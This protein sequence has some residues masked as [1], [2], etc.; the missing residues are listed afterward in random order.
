MRWLITSHHLLI[1]TFI[2]WLLNNYGI[3]STKQSF[4]WNFAKVSYSYMS[5]IFNASRVYYYCHASVNRKENHVICPLWL[6]FSATVLPLGWYGDVAV[7]FYLIQCDLPQYEPSISK[8]VTI[9]N[10]Q[11]L[12]VTSNIK[13]MFF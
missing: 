4:F 5:C 7:F 9:Y 6:N 12:T 3:V 2:L 1:Q 11:T 10:L 13:Q 8:N